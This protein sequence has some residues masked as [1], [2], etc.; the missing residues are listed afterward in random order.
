MVQE[1]S[2]DQLFDML[3]QTMS[4]A[5]QLPLVKVDRE[6]FLRQQFKD[7]PYLDK[8]LEDGPQS[9][10]ELDG[11]RKKAEHII[12]DMTTQTSLISFAAGIPAN[13]FTAVAAGTA[14]VVQYF[15]FTLNLAQQIA[16]LFGEAEL[17]PKNGGKEI[18]KEVEM[19]IIAYVGVMFGAGGAS[20]L[21]H[22]VAKQ[23]GAT[24][25]KK[26]AQKAL[27]KTLWYPLV[28]KVGSVIGYK[29]TKK[30]VEKTIANAVPLLGGI[31]SGTLTYMTFRPMGGQLADTFIK[32][33]NGD[34][35]VDLELNQAFAQSLK[36]QEELGIVDAD[37]VEISEEDQS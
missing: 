13:P 21:L 15:G 30:T 16:Y 5:S 22:K 31:I 24:I 2:Q 18:S 36:E 14:D 28:K 26:V 35:D 27:T 7:S 29:I 33:L 19:R 1:Q 17:F 11:L 8:I 6:A 25:G 32:Q 10:Y 37:F 9:V 4:A 12:N 34:F 3:L 20:V 23:A